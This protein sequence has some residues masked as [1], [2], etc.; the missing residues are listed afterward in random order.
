MEESTDNQAFFYISEA[1]MVKDTCGQLI[2]DWENFPKVYSKELEEEV[3]TVAFYLL[4]ARVGSYP[5]YDGISHAMVDNDSYIVYM[6]RHL[7][8]NCT[9]ND[10]VS[11]NTFISEDMPL[12]YALKCFDGLQSLIERECRISDFALY[13][14]IEDKIGT[15][16]QGFTADLFALQPQRLYGY[17]EDGLPP[18]AQ[19]DLEDEED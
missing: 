2:G 12:S 14:Y 10:A 1:L 15:R 16:E 3:I 6:Q 17:G 13:A 9:D 7:D 19:D 11:R 8:V 5:K 4:L 18:F